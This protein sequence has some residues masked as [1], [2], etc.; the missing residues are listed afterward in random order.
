MRSLT[1]MMCL[2][3]IGCAGKTPPIQIGPSIISSTEEDFPRAVAKSIKNN[4][5]RIYI[6]DRQ[7]GLVSFASG[8]VVGENG[9]IATAKHVVEAARGHKLYVV[10]NEDGRVTIRYVFGS[11]THP[12][13]DA[14]LLLVRHQFKS[15]TLP[16]FPALLPNE[17][18]FAVG[19]PMSGKIHDKP[20]LSSG[21]FF[22]NT[23]GS[24][25]SVLQRSYSI[26]AHLPIDEGSSGGPI[27]DR[28]G[29]VAGLLSAAK[30]KSHPSKYSYSMI[31][32]SVYI[33][34]LIISCSIFNCTSLIKN[35]H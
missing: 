28:Y 17:K 10:I 15:K 33:K 12:D 13:A 14:A 34:V 16:R 5:V 3:L 26:L 27:F 18:L 8:F 6:K 21:N 30:N 1:I 25:L 4:I 31:T 19:F 35:V 2:F 22:K 29:N 7:G 11:L 23:P 32:P 9:L 24:A 20:T